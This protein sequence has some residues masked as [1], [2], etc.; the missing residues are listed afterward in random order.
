VVFSLAIHSH[1]EDQLIKNKNKGKKREL[2]SG[3]EETLSPDS[4]F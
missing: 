2:G 1:I 4:K 3:L